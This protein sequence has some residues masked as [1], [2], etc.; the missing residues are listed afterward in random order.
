M[1][2]K[3]VLPDSGPCKGALLPPAVIDYMITRMNK[4]ARDLAISDLSAKMKRKIAAS[5]GVALP[6]I[7]RK[8]ASQLLR[9]KFG[10]GVIN[11]KKL[12][13]LDERGRGHLFTDGRRIPLAYPAIGGKL[14]TDRRAW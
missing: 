1:N 9:D 6:T 3:S 11:T 2:R 12:L 10:P 8:D 5:F 13:E 7:S 14:V 4:G